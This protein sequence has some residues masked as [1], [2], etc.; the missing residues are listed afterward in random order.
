MRPRCVTF[1]LLLTTG[2][3]AA[4]HPV[5]DV[6]FD[7]VH[8]QILIETWVNGEGPFRFVLDTGTHAT[9]IDIELATRLGLPLSTVK[10]E[11]TGAGTRRIRAVETLCSAVRVG[12][13][14]V[15]KVPATA[16]D[17]VGVSRAIGR[18]LDGVLGSGFLDGSI[19]Q[20]DYFRR[21]IRFYS[22]SPFS[23]ALRPPDSPRRFAV[24]MYFHEKSVLP[25]LDD[26][27]VNGTPVPLTVD[28]GSS[29]GLILFPR[30][31]RTLGLVDLAREGTP[32]NA[33]G[34]RG[35]VRFTKG[36]VR[37][38]RLRT[39]DLGAIEVAYVESGYGDT[40]DPKVRSGNLGN[41]ILQDF[42]VTLDYV[43]RVVIFE[44]NEE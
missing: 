20:I 14:T 29:F 30:A 40:E 7:F 31:V 39:I 10:K 11:G 1:G 37:S 4:V 41:A 33:V 34:Y 12:G 38:L 2:L 9:T 6:P 3:L 13:Y 22:Q 32:L 25:V 15:R 42:L 24:P 44:S 18:K 28:T 16:I 36:W 17:F 8:N 21:H 27:S 19:T 35:K 23:P 43:N 26:C 5:A